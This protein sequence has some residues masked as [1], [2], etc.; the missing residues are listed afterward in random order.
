MGI[1]TE[2]RPLSL[3]S[4]A[5]IK[6]NMTAQSIGRPRK[7]DKPDKLQAI[8]LKINHNL[9][10]QEI[11]KMQGKSRQAV[12]QQIAREVK[13]LSPDDIDSTEYQERLAKT[14]YGKHA[15]IIQSIDDKVIERAGLG[16]RASAAG[17]ILSDAR[18][19]MG[20]PSSLVGIGIA[21]SEPMQAAVERIIT[22]S[23]PVDNSITDITASNT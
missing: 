12:H 19:A 2:T 3:L 9:T 13:E 4:Q 11:A 1:T 10:Y 22:R 7:I 15:K 17:R 8:D 18:V 16:E 21:L 20:K 23:M 14:L 6:D 5:Y